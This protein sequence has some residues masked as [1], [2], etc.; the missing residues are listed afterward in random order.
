MSKLIVV[1]P[2][3]DSESDI[4]VRKKLLKR[5]KMEQGKVVI[6]EI[7]SFYFEDEE[8]ESIQKPYELIE[9]DWNDF[10]WYVYLDSIKPSDD[11]IKEFSQF[12]YKNKINSHEHLLEFTN[13]NKA[14]RKYYNQIFQ[15]HVDIDNSE[16]FY[17]SIISPFNKS[18]EIFQ[19]Y[20]S[21]GDVLIGG[22]VDSCLKE[23]EF[24]YNVMGL[25]YQ[26]DHPY[27]YSG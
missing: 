7:G 1:H 25:S 19:D 27:T 4:E 17:D 23:L 14:F 6:M 2:P 3:N 22:S 12:L 5:I 16:D 13:E 9:K 10:G 11:F 20:L 18:V 24:M 26:I 21:D 8:K 15:Q